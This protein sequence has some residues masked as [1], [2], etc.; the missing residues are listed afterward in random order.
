MLVWMKEDCA[1]LCYANHRQREHGAASP[2]V[3]LPPDAPDLLPCRSQLPALCLGLK[4]DLHQSIQGGAPAVADALAAARLLNPKASGGWCSCAWP[5]QTG[6][7]LP[8]LI[9]VTPPVSHT[10]TT[11]PLR[12]PLPDVS[13]GP[14]KVSW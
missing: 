2:S 12:T 13:Q 8:W 3:S 6:F 14:R 1:V 7:G 9:L 11:A 10:Q 4:S 5:W